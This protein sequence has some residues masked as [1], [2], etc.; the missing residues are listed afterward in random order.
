MTNDKEKLREQFRK[1]VKQVSEIFQNK[2]ANVREEMEK[3][4]YTW[5]D[6]YGGRLCLDQN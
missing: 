3:I 1:K 4:G 5:V 2:P 6:D